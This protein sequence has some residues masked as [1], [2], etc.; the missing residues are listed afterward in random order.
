MATLKNVFKAIILLL[1][2]Y[3]CAEVSIDFERNELLIHLSLFLLIY[4][5]FLNVIIQ[6]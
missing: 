4:N 2:T 6:K 1:L 5:D 3:I